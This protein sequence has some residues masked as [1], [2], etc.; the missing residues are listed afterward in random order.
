MR[1]AFAPVAIAFNLVAARK[2][3]H[4]SYCCKNVAPELQVIDLQNFIQNLSPICY[5]VPW[6]G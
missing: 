5:C 6:L 3:A 1:L 4:F 2:V